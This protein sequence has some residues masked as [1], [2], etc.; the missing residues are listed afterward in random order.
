MGHKARIVPLAVLVLY[1]G[2]SHEG[3]HR[4]QRLA[5]LPVN[6]LIGDESAQWISTGL[7]LALEEDFATSPGLVATVVND[8]SGAYQFGA[9]AVL[10]ATVE[11]RQGGFHVEGSMTGMSTQRNL[12]TV[13]V[14]IPASGL[15]PFANAFAK[16]IDNRATDFPT[17]NERAFQMFA[18]ALQS[19]SLQTRMQLLND[20]IS[21][22]PAFGLAYIALAQTAA[23]ANPNSVPALLAKAQEHA[24]SFIPLDRAR[25][26]AFAAQALHAPIARQ[27]AGLRGLLQL[28][29]NTLDALTGLGAISF[30]GGDAS[31]GERLMTRALEL[32][33]GN[34]NVRQQLARGLL[35]SRR[36]AD[37]EKMLAGLDNN[38]AVLPSLAVC[39][40]LEGDRARADTI[41]EQF[42]RSLYPGV[43]ALYRATWFAVSGDPA[44]ALTTIEGVNFADPPLQSA[45]LA[46]RVIWQLMQN[47]FA[48]AKGSAAA[49]AEMPGLFTSEAVLLSR[50]DEPLDQWR[51]LVDSSGMNAGRKQNVLGYG[52]FLGA[53][54]SE[55]AQIWQKALDTSGGAD[56]GARAMLASSLGHA[57]NTQAARKVLVEPFVPDF[58][59]AYAAISFG[60]M[61]RLLNLQMQ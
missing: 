32:S 23:Q 20:A 2:C 4:L 17:K 51:A 40:L 58:G 12:K 16:R 61:R 13:D 18:A 41:A 19:A 52:L 59:D 15:L 14:D 24:G 26:H 49:A 25:L 46:H 55:A 60:E 21:V 8:V 54:Y 44:K 37:A 34:V 28:A 38:P 35:E 53:H 10:R 33:P 47:N 27:E 5:I 42:S 36:F 48:A 50:A 30:I 43:Q 1:S 9:N 6:V 3:D 56:L 7:P 29:P 45:A 39:I 57:G 11:R 31:G 22:D